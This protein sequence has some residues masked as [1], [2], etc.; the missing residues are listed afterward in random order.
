MLNSIHT[1][2][3]KT[4]TSLQEHFEPFREHTIGIRHHIHTPY[5]RQPLLY[6]DWTASGRLYEPIERKL[7]EAFGPYVSNPHTDSNTTGLTMTMAYHKARNIIKKHVNAGPHDTLLFCGNGTT[8]AVNKLQR[9][10]GLKQPEWLH[11][12][13]LDRKSVV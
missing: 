4:P 1:S 12:G 13:P 11:S 3:E 7:Q 9:L 10:M 8:G 6:A 2:P 5:G